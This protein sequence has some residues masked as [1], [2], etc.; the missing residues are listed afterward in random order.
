[1]AVIVRDSTKNGDMW[2]EWATLLNAT[3]F[4]A[5]AQQNDYDDLVKALANEMK[6]KR[7]G[8]VA[9]TIGG[10]G[11]FDTKVEGE[12]AA[13]DIAIE[14]YKKFV[15][16]MTFSKTVTV[17]KEWKDDNMIAEAKA[18][19]L[20]MVQSYKRS[21]AKFLSNALIT[22]VGNT[23]TMT[24]GS[25]SGI[26]ISGADGL[27]LFNAAHP[28][29]AIAASILPIGGVTV[30]PTQSNLFSNPLGSDS[31]MLNKLSNIMRNFRD[32]RGE[33]LGLDADTVIVPGNRPALEDLVKKIIG[34]D[35]EVG[36]NNN[37]I[38]TQRGRWKLVVDPLWT[39]ATGDPY[40]LMSSKANKALLGTRVYDRTPLDVE[41]DV[42]VKSRNLIYNGFARMS[43]GF[44]NWRHVLMGGSSDATATTLS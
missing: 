44:T 20:N 18:K 37:D 3:I 35:G 43:V 21:R 29:K 5:D 7:W 31:V 40:I 2:N 9:T 11:D 10:L 22:S 17:S 23:K 38:N 27:A 41:N 34:S 30:D 42:E 32:D 14:G 25:T 33:V 24:W 4:D 28:L 8:E 36:S 13:D 12:N 39:P 26:D 19:M 6:S 16:H 15:E 1:M